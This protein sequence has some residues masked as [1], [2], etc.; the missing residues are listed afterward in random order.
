MAALTLT[1]LV[2]CSTPEPSKESAYVKLANE[3]G[4]MISD[5]TATPEQAKLSEIH[6]KLFKTPIHTISENDAIEPPKLLKVVQPKYP[7]LAV[8]TRMT[9]TVNVSAI[10][11]ESGRVAE[12][13]V[14]SSSWPLFEASA[15]E[16][17]SQWIFSPAKKDGRPINMVVTIPVVFAPQ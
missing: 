3:Q 12:A 15:L 13:K 14:V 5:E 11:D 17:I 9:G 10:V 8:K 7:D 6:R 4:A 1:T 2:G 16:A